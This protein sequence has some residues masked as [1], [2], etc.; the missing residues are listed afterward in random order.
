M[1]RI[2]N[3]FLRYV[4]QYYALYDISLNIDNGEKVAFIGERES[5][6]TSLIRT[7]IKLEKAQKG[8]IYIRNIP[9]KKVNFAEDVS[10][11]YLPASPIF[12]ENKTVRENLLY[13]EK[14]HFSRR[15][16]MENAINDVLKE[17]D[18]EALQDNIVSDLSLYQKYIVSLARLALR[19]IDIL[20]VDDVLD[21][22]KDEQR[23]S[24][25]SIL[26]SKFLGD[27]T[28]FILSTADEN[29]AGRLCGR[30]VFFENGSIV[31]ESSKN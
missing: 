9:I 3:L 4:R 1:I 28:I 15:A 10:V 24:V 30:F 31:K 5:G 25:I 14:M 17:F 12:F 18:I 26:K 19:K 27:E 7:L 8:E 6:K 23:E 29:L 22:L 16:E 21:V 11:G 2:K 20:I 13:V